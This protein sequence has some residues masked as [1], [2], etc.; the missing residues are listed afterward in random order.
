M[1]GDC[2]SVLF[3]SFWHHT[4]IS[5]PFFLH[6]FQGVDRSE[7]FFGCNPLECDLKTWRHVGRKALCR[8]FNDVVRSAKKSLGGLGGCIVR[9]RLSFSIRLWHPPWVIQHQVVASSSG[10]GSQHHDHS[11]GVH[12]L[13]SNE[14]TVST[15]CTPGM[16]D[17]TGNVSHFIVPYFFNSYSMLFHF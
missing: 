16:G 10:M 6:H 13:I 12:V 15:E 9:T 14:E 2:G 1:Y 3:N 7:C 5:L 17:V 11:S 8:C 4:L